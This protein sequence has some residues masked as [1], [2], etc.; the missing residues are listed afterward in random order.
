MR[1]SLRVETLAERWQTPD[2]DVVEI[3]RLQLDDVRAEAPR[4]LVL[5]GLEGTIDSH[6]LRGILDLARQRG[7][8]ADVFLFRGC[9]GE[10]NRA[11]RIYHSGETS[12]LQFVVDTLIAAEPQR[13][14][15]LVGFSLGGNV[16]LKWL[17]EGGTD[18]PSQLCA[19]AA[20][21]VPFDLEQ[22]CRHIEQGFSRVY[23]KHF[24]RSLKDKAL[25][26][27]DQFPGL[28]SREALLR[29]TTLYDFDDAV[30]APVHGFA[31]AH[32]YYS[33][34][35]SI[36]FLDGIR[37]PTLLLSA[38]DDPFLPREVLD[39][40]LLVAHKSTAITV[41]FHEFGGH[42]GFVTGTMPW[43]QHF[44]AE[45]RAIEFVSKHVVPIPDRRMANP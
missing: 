26:K 21:S 22:G 19:A 32:D 10:P 41:E 42:V 3:R 6:Y 37:V 33:R 35:S 36:R 4:L 20:I 29:A 7:W 24:L 2:N 40:V 17:G 1:R 15:V 5:H 43:Q 12:D 13:P 31:D 9:N 23:N 27:L 44:Y 28:F 39:D 25:K 16:L 11:R 8:P 38:K 34:C 18:I 14:I 30:T 45:E